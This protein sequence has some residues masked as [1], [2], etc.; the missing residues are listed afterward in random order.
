LLAASLIA[1]SSQ[2]CKDRTVILSALDKQGPV[3]NLV[4]ANFKAFYRGRPVSVSSSQYRENPAERVVVLLDVSESMRGARYSNKW[5]VAHAMASDFV[6]SAP[7]GTQISFR[8]FSGEVQEKFEASG[9]RKPIEDWLASSAVRDGSKTGGR[10]A[11]LEA[12]LAAIQEL[13]PV[14]PGDAIFV[15]TDGGDNHSQ[16]SS[17]VVDRSLLDSGTRLFAFVLNEDLNA[18][19]DR[20]RREDLENTV[21]RS[22]GLLV[23]EN[24]VPYGTGAERFNSD[25]KTTMAMQT[26]TRTFLSQMRNFYVLTIEGI[27]PSGKQ[28]D[29]NLN[30]VDAGGRER[31]DIVSAYTPWPTCTQ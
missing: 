30:V 31:K 23:K 27:D 3:T 25:D 28:K 20:L 21:R 11:L 15:I 16:A 18:S 19:H 5:R 6:S 9:G 10:T 26:A 13:R 2:E 14:Q 22:G 4:A 24:S 8:S 12:I 1:Q 29:L 17:V 7:P